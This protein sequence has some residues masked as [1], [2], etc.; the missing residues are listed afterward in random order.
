[1]TKSSLQSREFSERRDSTCLASDNRRHVV[2]TG[3]ASSKNSFPVF[4]I[5]QVYVIQTCT[6]TLYWGRIVNQRRALSHEDLVRKLLD[7]DYLIQALLIGA[8]ACRERRFRERFRLLHSDGIILTRV[9]WD[10]RNLPCVTNAPI[11]TQQLFFG[12]G[13]TSQAS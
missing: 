7:L 4:T 6:E 8:L 12:L 10:I 5:P 9:L 13:F 2:P 3:P 11:C 1:M